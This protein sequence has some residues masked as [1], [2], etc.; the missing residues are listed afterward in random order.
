MNR[1]NK[2]NKTQTEKHK[3]VS[4][5]SQPYRRVPS[6]CDVFHTITRMTRIEA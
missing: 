6:L 1:R 5:I 4:T 2:D 3:K